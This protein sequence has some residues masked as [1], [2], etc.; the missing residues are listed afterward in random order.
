MTNLI[1]LFVI[2]ILI[3]AFLLLDK[4]DR[5]IN[6]SVY[7]KKPFL[8]DSHSELVLYKTLVELFNEQYLIFPQIN[9]NHLIQPKKTTW[10]K[11]RIYRSRIDR[12]S[13]DFV[14]CDKERVI[15]LLVIELDG[16]HHNN[17]DKKKRD[18]FIDQITEVINLPILHL[19]IDNLD[20][21][22]I[23]EEI[24]KKINSQ[25]QEN[26]RKRLRNVIKI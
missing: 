18:E 21:E 5:K 26:T 2:I 11:A 15:P 14:L 17:K 7:E 3:V 1:L 6:L 12:K 25:S 20:K 24:V 19:K 8:F 16:P 9:Y 23:K 13:A 4:L 10:Q 22:F